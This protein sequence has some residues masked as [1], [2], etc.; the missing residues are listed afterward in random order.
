S[1]DATRVALA[2]TADPIRIL[3]LADDKVTELK[4]DPRKF[5]AVAYSPDGKM[6]AAGSIDGTVDVWDAATGARLTSL[7]AHKGQITSVAFSPDN[8]ALATA[9]RDKT[10]QVWAV[11]GWKSV[12]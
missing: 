5:L 7:A 2:G 1:P 11:A 4:G 3:E 10:V 9:G 8:T 12:D 6:V